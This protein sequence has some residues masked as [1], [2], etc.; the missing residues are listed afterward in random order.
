MCDFNT[1]DYRTQYF[2]P[3]VLKMSEAVIDIE[4]VLF[5]ARKEFRFWIIS[6][7]FVW[8]GGFVCDGLGFLFSFWFYFS[9]KSSFKF[10]FKGWLCVFFFS[11]FCPPFCFHQPLSYA[12]SAFYAHLKLCNTH[13]SIYF[14]LPPTFAWI[15]MCAHTCYFSLFK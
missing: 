10:S 11:F 2:L 6:Q 9:V 1:K 7:V 5:L 13:H 14:I 3:S 15:C 12:K 4:L 8:L